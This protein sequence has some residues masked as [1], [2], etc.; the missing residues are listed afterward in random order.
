M[1]T[2]TKND[3]RSSRIIALVLSVVLILSMMPIGA[4]LT[5]FAQGVASF[6]VTLSGY[7]KDAQVCLTNTAEATDTSTVAAVNGVAT[8]ENFVDDEKEYNLTVTELVGYEDYQKDNLTFTS[9]QTN[10]DVIDFVELDKVAISGVVTDENGQPYNDASVAFSAYNEK[11]TGTTSTN[12][13][14]EYSF[15]A[16]KGQKYDITAT[17]K[18]EKYNVSTAFVSNPTAT[19][20]DANMQLSIKQFSID[21]TVGLNGT[22]TEDATVNYGTEKKVAATAADGYRISSFKVDGNEENAAKGEKTYSYDFTNITAAHSISV[23]FERKTYTIAFTV[24]ANGKVTYNDGTAQEVAGGTVNI[25]KIFEESTD[26]ENPK[27]VEVKANPETNYR[28]SK[29]T[30]DGIDETFSDNNYEYTKEFTMT[31]DHSFVVEFA[32]NTYTVTIGNTENGTAYIGDGTDTIKTVNHGD[33]PIIKI[34]PNNGYIL[35]TLTVNGTD[36]LSNIQMNDA[37]M[38]LTLD[39]IASDVTI[40][41][42]FSEVVAADPGDKLNNAYYTISFSKTECKAA[43]M[44]GTTYVVVLPHDA[45]ATISPVSPY[46]KVK[47]NTDNSWDGSQT[48]V[49]NSTTTI[50]N[51]IAIKTVNKY[52]ILDVNVRIIID[53]TAPVVTPEKT[54]LNWSNA[55]SVEIKGTVTDEN[56]VTNPSSAVSH[57]VWSKDDT[58]TPAQVLAETTNK[59]NVTSG[60]Y[61]FNSVTGEQNSTYYIYAVDYAGNVSTGKTVK[62]KIDRTNPQITAFSFNKSSSLLDTIISYLTFGTIASN[63][64][65]V[66]VT[67]ADQNISSGLNEITLYCGDEVLEKKVVAENSATFELSEAKFKSGKEIS[68]TVTDIAGNISG[69]GTATKPTDTGVTTDAKSDIVKIDSAK[70]TVVITPA[71]AEYTSSN[72]QLW[73]NANTALNVT[74]SDDNAGIKSV[75]IKL[76]NLP[77]VSD[78]N[79]D[80]V[81]ADFSTG[82]EPVHNKTFVINTSQNTSDGENLLEVVVTNNAGVKSEVYQQKVY[83][84]TTK[85]NIASFNVE[86]VHTSI[87]EKAINFL[88]FGIFCNDEVEVTVTADDSPATSGIK[89]ITLFVDSVEYDTMAIDGENKCVFT[90]PTSEITGEE[91]VFNKKLSAKSTDNVG[92]I[93]ENEVYPNTINSDIEN[94]GLMIETVKPLVDVKFADPAS[95]KNTDTKDTNDWYAGDVAFTVKATD[96]HSGIA[97]VEISINGTALTVDKDNNSISE[98]FSA[99]SAKT[100]EETF[101]VNTDQVTIASDGSYTLNVSVTDNAGNV[102]ILYTKKIYKDTDKPVIVG[103][104]FAATDYIEGSE[105]ATTV[106]KTDYGFY[107]KEDTN[108]TITARDSAPTSGI[109]SITYYTV[110]VNSGKSAEATTLVDANNQ[111]TFTVPANFKGQIYA[112]ATDNVD[113]VAADF[114]N[115]NSAIVEN[116]AKHEEETHIAFAKE[117]TTYKANDNTELYAKDVPVTITVTDTYSGIR[118][119]E[120]SV[121]APYDTGNNKSG[122]VVLN[123]DKTVSAD[124]D[125]DWEQTKIEVN[126]VTEMKKTVTV[127]NNSNNIIVKVTMTDRAGNTSVQ[128]IELSIDK[129]K[130]VIDVVYDNNTPDQDFSDFYKADR[131]AT[132]TVTE[133]NF[134]AQDIVY[135]ITNTD[136]VIPVISNWTEHKN[137]ENPDASYY[138]A[139]ILYHADGD[140]TF[141]ISY[142]DLA[143]NAADAFAQHKFTIDQTVPT[144]NVVYDNTTALN[145]NYYAADRTATITINEHNFETGRIVVTGTATDN[146]A[147]A[148]FPVTSEWSTNGDIHVATIHYSSDAKYSFDIAYKDKAGND[149]ADYAVEEFFVD[150]TAPTLVITGVADKSANNGDVIPAISFSDTNYNANG[151]TVG[152]S[153][154]NN[155]VAKVNGA[156]S[157]IA[158]GQTFTFV[159]FEKTKENDDI[160]TMTAKVVDFAGNETS[161]TITFS[162][163]RFG[164]VYTFDDSLTGIEGKYVQKEV[165]VVLTETNVDSLKSGT[166]KLKMTKN[167]TPT[168]LAEG[169][170]YTVAESGGNGQWSQYKYTVNKSLFANDGRYTVTL[171][172]EDAAG[173]INENIDESKEAEISFGVDKTAP[174]IVPVDFE[175]DKQYPV[176]S[177]TVS[178]E[179]KDN[180]VLE[181][182]KIY[183]ND[184]EVKYDQNGETYTFDIAQMNSKQN[185]KFVATDAAGNETPLTVDGFLVSTNLFIR[186]YNN[187]PLFVGSLIGV[188]LLGIGIASLVV[189]GKKKKKSTDK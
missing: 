161:Q 179:I 10:Y 158:N 11:L 160:Y 98:N 51:I 153:G 49:I 125:T 121:I 102:S 113:N 130:P 69:N 146:G 119:I 31:G 137:T 139:T 1:L 42:G 88:S 150:K 67:A 155:G 72:G 182:V 39:A 187:T 78:I 14:G 152:L 85:P 151:I 59:V 148:T 188:G 38:S 20:T 145:G 60:N 90:I 127:N 56:T 30:V 40:E 63:K 149:A 115:P 29:V 23:T 159:N 163:N 189:F 116:A 123:N 46:S 133:R 76:N 96:E 110:D 44:D 162:V 185:V 21:T 13:S 107:F 126:L 83:I 24:S 177:K 174:V 7:D 33:T 75:E 80:S 16:Y 52:D 132:V 74:I 114:V 50:S 105:N 70:P 66:T 181:G 65:N 117:E 136:N 43:Y 6:T 35:S 101:V 73:Y 178:V 138:T 19:V 82:T 120:W 91:L 41:V 25:E 17:A 180:L 81:N 15:E 147:T 2:K 118:S 8:F 54:E 186:W 154:I 106:E 172:S 94:S 22:I 170:D 37:D 95:N 175:S 26:P 34:V 99:R 71:T 12:A 28:V 128:E 64:I 171:Y 87:I 165:D 18:E 109:K 129:K 167:G 156:Y 27:K 79:G 3:K 141:D 45:T 103:F 53:Q 169:T 157:E 68:A 89:E 48:K 62:V 55:E 164:S 134:K 111:I 61:S 131:T 9:G 122:K 124:S 144:I 93:T 58:L 47:Y 92:N 5:A 183:L 140:Y 97:K 142:S 112:K 36:K 176:E 166:I 108:V 57:I 84:D 86:R 184:K 104:D 77:I 173:N 32:K 135:L 100:N 143:K 4:V 168:D